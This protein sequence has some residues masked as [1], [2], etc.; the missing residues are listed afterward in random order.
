MSIPRSLRGTVLIL[1]LVAVGCATPL[2]DRPPIPTEPIQL[3]A[4]EWRITD[5]TIVITDAS[6]TMYVNETFPTAKSL[7]RSAT[8]QRSSSRLG[9]I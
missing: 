4:S 3:G 9:R 1:S 5:H 2:A 8:K 7:A 6:G